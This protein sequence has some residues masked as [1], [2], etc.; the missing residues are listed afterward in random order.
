MYAM[1]HAWHL[2]SMHPCPSKGNKKHV[3]KYVKK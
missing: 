3:N 1:S 2:C